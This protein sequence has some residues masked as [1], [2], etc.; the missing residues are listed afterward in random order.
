VTRN[1][2]NAIELG[3]DNIPL[4]GEYAAVNKEPKIRWIHLLRDILIHNK[5]SFHIA[6][7]CNPIQLFYSQYLDIDP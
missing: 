3:R 2:P 6:A 4:S 1:Q 7:N 5:F